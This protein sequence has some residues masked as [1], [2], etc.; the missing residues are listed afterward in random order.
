MRMFCMVGSAMLAVAAAAVT[1]CCQPQAPTVQYH[2]L[3][4]QPGRD[5]ERAR[6]LDGESVALIRCG[7][8]AEAERTLKAALEADLT[9]G[10]AH[11]N[12]GVVYLQSKRFYLAA[13]EFQYAS[14]LMP[15]DPRPRN[16]LGLVFEAVGQLDKAAASYD[17]ALALETDN[18]EF[19]GN[20]A[21]I[22][23]RSGKDPEKLRQ[24]LTE[25][26]FKDDRPDWV[27]WAR[28]RL[29]LLGGPVPMPAAPEQPA[30]EEV[31]PW[32][33]A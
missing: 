28:Q 9:Y 31:V 16:N 21:R 10:P 27:E 19:I 22:Y 26:V 20:L 25:L 30:V 4:P 2:T 33:P 8:L 18:P 14:Q 32:P 24:L 7:Q 11:N 5:S 6:Q 17:E 15:H 23:A 1:G 12:L 3:P 13:W 29:S